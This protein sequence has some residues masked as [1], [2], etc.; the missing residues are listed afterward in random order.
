MTPNVGKV[1][2]KKK[3]R[4]KIVSREVKMRSLVELVLAA[5]RNKLKHVNRE[6]KVARRTAEKQQSQQTVRKETTNREKQNNTK[7]KQAIN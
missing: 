5:L 7:G 4:S 2:L 6:H 3:T 1:L